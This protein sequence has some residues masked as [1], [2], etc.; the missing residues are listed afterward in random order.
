MGVITISREFGCSANEIAALVAQQLGYE[1]VDKELISHIAAEA[2]VP[3]EEVARY[4]ESAMSPIERF[5]KALVRFSTPEDALSWSPGPLRESPMWLPSPEQWKKEGA[6]LLDHEECLRFTQ[7]ALHKLA[8]RGK[9]ILIGRGGMVLLK[10]L[11]TALHVRLV[12]PLAWR[13]Q[14]LMQQ[15]GLSEDKARQRI[16][17]E[18]KQRAGYIRQFYGVDWNDPT[19][20][21]LVLN[22]ASLGLETT[23]NLIVTAAQTKTCRSAAGRNL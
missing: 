2:Q 20:Y 10:D 11:P 18:D 8:Q 22:V 1:V 14:R 23:A 9:V 19:L 6:R 15:E 5:L 16:L 7:M 12:A 3:E 17:C 13:V 4:D 21:H